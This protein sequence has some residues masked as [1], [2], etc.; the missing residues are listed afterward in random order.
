[1]REFCLTPR[2]PRPEDASYF[3][4]R[5]L[6]YKL[7]EPE[8]YESHRSDRI[9]PAVTWRQRVRHEVD[10]E[11]PAGAERQMLGKLEIAQRA[12]R[13][14]ADAISGPILDVRALAILDHLAAPEDRPSRMLDR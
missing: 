12:Q 11:Q 7:V 13:D 3:R 4:G 2:S 14:L 6:D 1:M 9:V 10:R 5:T 8:P